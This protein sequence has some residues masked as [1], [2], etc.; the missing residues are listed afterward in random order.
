[1]QQSEHQKADHEQPKHGTYYRNVLSFAYTS[2]VCLYDEIL[3]LFSQFFSV[4]LY[5]SL[6][7]GRF[8]SSL[9]LYTVGRVPLMGDQPVARPLPTRRATQAE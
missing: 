3:T 2:S 4:W 1:M 8:F 6:D 5:S 7:L 9:I